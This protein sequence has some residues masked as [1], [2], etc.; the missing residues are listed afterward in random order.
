[1][2]RVVLAAL[3]GV[4]VAFGACSSSKNEDAAATADAGVDAKEPIKLDPLADFTCLG[5]VSYPAPAAAAVAFDL[6]AVDPSNNTGIPDVNLKACAFTDVDCTAPLDTAKTGVGGLGTFT[7]LPL[8]P[9]GFDG[10]FEAQYEK[11]H[12]NLNF[13][14]PV[15]AKLPAYGR[16]YWGDAQMQTLLDSANLKVEKGRGILGVQVHDCHQLPGGVPCMDTATETTCRS[17]LPGGIVI[18][19]DVVD[20]KMTRAYI[21]LDGSHAY[22]STTDEATSS[23]SGIGG[24][25]NVPPGPATVTATIG[26]TGQKLG[27]FKTF[28]RPDAYSMLVLMPQ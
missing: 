16:F 18:T 10:Y 19:V 9:N 20:P 15:Y 25:I 17:H 27:T 1:M 11:E 21:H 7:K 8:G 4:A 5:K 22:V 24:F 23:T 14:Q 3:V 2:G 26:A 12:A 6:T 28:V 13:Q